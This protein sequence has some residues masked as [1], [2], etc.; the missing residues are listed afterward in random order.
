M[1]R[2]CL[3]VSQDLLIQIHP[4]KVT[5]ASS[6]ELPKHGAMTRLQHRGRRRNAVRTRGFHYELSS[7]VVISE[8]HLGECPHICP[9]CSLNR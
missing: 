5:I 1:K 8:H 4:I 3:L 6:F 7:A 2:K 9:A